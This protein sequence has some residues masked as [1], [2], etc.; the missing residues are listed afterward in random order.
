MASKITLLMSISSITV[1]AGLCY[2]EDVVRVEHGCSLVGDLPA[3]Q[4]KR[5]SNLEG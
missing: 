3:S 4:E 1:V 2:V 5:Q